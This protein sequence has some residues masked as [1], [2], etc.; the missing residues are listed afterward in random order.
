MTFAVQREEKAFITEETSFGVIP[1]A[2]ASGE[3][4]R[5]MEIVVNKSEDRPFR[6][7]KRNSRS[8]LD[9]ITMRKSVSWSIR[10]YLLPGGAAGTAPDGWDSILEAAFGTETIN[11]GVSVVYNVTKEFEKSFTLTRAYGN[12]LAYAV[13][14]EAVRGC[15]PQTVT[16]NLSGNEPAMIEVSGVAADVLHASKGTISADSGTVVTLG[17]GEAKGYDVGMYVNI[18]SIADHVISALDESAHTITVAAHAAQTPGEFVV[19]AA[20]VKSQTFGASAKPIGGILGSCSLDATAF[21]IISAQVVLNNNPNIHND[22][23]GTDKASGFS[24]HNRE[25]TGSITFRV[26]HS[27]FYDLVKSKSGSLRDLQ[28]V[29]GTT[30]GLIATFDLNT[31][32]FDLTP[33]PS[34]EEGDLIVT[35]PF[36]ALGSSGEDELTLTFT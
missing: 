20:V 9:I 34:G 23:Y 28:L 2:P 10:G 12:A 35:M 4:I 32:V 3:A 5:F 19:P 15:V 31:V 16:F 13:G 27:N 26:T 25:V 11:G 7:D 33:I 1:S 22:K 14:A 30:A 36:R 21:S 6:R 17:T 29:A 18:D 8:Y 24:M